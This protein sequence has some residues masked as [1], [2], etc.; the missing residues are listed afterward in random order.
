MNQPLLPIE[1][2][3]PLKCRAKIPPRGKPLTPA[4]IGSG[5]AG[6]TCGTCAHLAR[7]KPGAGVYLKCG[8]MRAHWT[9][10]SGTDI[11]A[12]WPACSE[13]ARKEFPSVRAEAVR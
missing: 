2:P 11:K 1:L 9:G 4:P 10:G 13:W 3:E 5:P 6:E 7:T 8:L 12:S